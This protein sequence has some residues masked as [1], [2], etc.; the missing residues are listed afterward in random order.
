MRRAIVCADDF[1]FSPAACRSILQLGEAGRISATSVAVDGSVVRAHCRELAALRPRL[2]VGLH[3]NLT[4]NPNFAGAR[5]LKGWIVTS[6]IGRQMQVPSDVLRQEVLRQFQLFEELFDAPPD[7]VDGHEHVH[8]FPG[9][10]EHVLET[11]AARYAGSVMAR[12]TE[13]RIYRG[14]K[15]SIIACLGGRAFARRLDQLDIGHNYDFAGVYDLQASTGYG[16]RMRDWLGGL[17]DGGLVMCHP[18]YG[19]GASA[20]RTHEHYWFAS[21]DWPALLQEL[22]VQLVPFSRGSMP[23]SPAAG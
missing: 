1:G 15:A 19:A 6:F 16:Q 8:Q 3:L 12:S 10:R 14:A 11:L 2:A 7:Y 18:E 20:A 22:Q 4:E 9:I 21:T 5:P 23:A 13:T 17:A